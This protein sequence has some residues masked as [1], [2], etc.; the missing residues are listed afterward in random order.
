MP[1]ELHMLRFV[2]RPVTK[3]EGIAILERDGY[4][5]Q[6]CGLDGMAS[7]ENALNMS[8]DF[9]V[10]RARKGKKDPRNLVACCRSC[11]MIKG[12][13]IYRDFDDAKQ[14]VLAQREVLREAWEDK[15]WQPASKSAKAK[16]AAA[17]AA[18]EKKKAATASIIGSSPL[19]IRK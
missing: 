3:E 17:A 19:S 13:K 10:P 1:L 12:T 8:V 11:N 9:V 2:E 18:P 15:K 6:Y 4:R 5:C 16:A 14:Y 7:F